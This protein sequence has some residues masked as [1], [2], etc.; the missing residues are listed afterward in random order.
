LQLAK[1]N[2]SWM[3]SDLLALTTTYHQ[4]HLY[5]ILADYYV[6]LKQ[7]PMAKEYYLK[8]LSISDTVIEQS[9]I[10]NKIAQLP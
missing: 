7:Y 6:T 3:W 10:Q 9:L 1:Q 8:A 4:S 5:H 2:L